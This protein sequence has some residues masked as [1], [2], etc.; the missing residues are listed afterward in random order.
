MYQSQP[1]K[2]LILYILDIL[3]KYTDSEH[4][5]SQKEILEILERDYSMKADRKSI[6]SNIIN[7]IEAGYAVEYKEIPRSNKNAK[8]GEV[9]DNNV[10]TD[11][12]LIKDFDDSELRLLI[13]SLLFSKH[14]PYSQCKR[15]I[16]KLEKL[17]SKYFRA[18]VKHI[19]TMPI[20]STNNKRLFYVI[21][22]LDEAINNN[23]Q[24]KFTYGYY[25]T[26]KKLHPSTHDDGTVHEYIVNPYQMA[27][28]NGRYYLIGNYDKYDNISHY[29]VDRIIDIEILDT[30]QKP[31]K[32]IK[33]V[34]S[35][36]DL[37]R[38]MTEHIY[39][40]SGASAT[41]TFRLKKYLLNDVIDF[42]GSEITFFDEKEDTVCA[43]V[44]VNLSAMRKWAVQYALHAKVLTPPSLAEGVKSDLVKAL[45]NYNAD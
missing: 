25:G 36:F 10:Y 21:E 35:G 13:D 11:Y 3:Q 32:E 7:L 29:R 42:F 28:S 26:D 33:E 43:R 20:S 15:L 12:Y 1:K 34:E 30:P 9:E 41:V 31:K 18:K 2:M 27:A 39:M 37:S 17:S 4:R 24:V 23:K 22:I 6:R 40:F 45:E 8:T 44:R 14:I 16:E 38:H 5:L 19:R